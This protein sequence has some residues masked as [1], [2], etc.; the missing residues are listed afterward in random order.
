[1]GQLPSESFL[2]SEFL[3]SLTRC[4]LYAQE[5]GVCIR[6]CG[7]E[8]QGPPKPRGDSEE[9]EERGLASRERERERPTDRQTD[10]VDPSGDFPVS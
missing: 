1:M 9:R 6:I 7:K 8:S 3:P 4:F 10:T 2:V 5:K